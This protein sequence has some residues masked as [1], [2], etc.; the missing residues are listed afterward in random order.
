M[1]PKTIDLIRSNDHLTLSR[2][3]SKVESNSNQDNDLLK[4]IYPL[5]NDLI[6]KRTFSSSW[7]PSNSNSYRI[8]AIGIYLFK[9][10]II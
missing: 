2:V 8:I 1:N 10:I 4:K 6:S 5:S 7:W 3:I 9:K